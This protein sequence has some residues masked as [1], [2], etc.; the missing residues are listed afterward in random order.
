MT[1]AE[2]IVRILEAYGPP[3]IFG[4]PGAHTVKLHVA[5]CRSPRLRHILVRHEQGAAFA[6]DGYARVAGRPGVFVTTAGPGATNAVTPVAESFTNSVPTLHLCCL[7]D[8]PFVGKQLGAW[9]EADVESIFKPVTKWSVTARSA[10]ETPC[11]VLQALH[12]AA[13]GRPRPTQVC[14]PRDLLSETLTNELPSPLA[15]TSYVPDPT[16][17]DAAVEAIGE[18][19]R[20][21]IVAGGG[22]VRAAGQLRTL[23]TTL[24]AGVATTCMGKGVFPEDDPL[25]LGIMHSPAAMRALQEA[26]LCLA[27]GCRFTQIAT[28]NWSIRLPERL[29]HIDIDPYVIDMHYVADIPIVADAAVALEA[30]LATLPVCTISSRQAWVDRIRELRA[31]DRKVNRPEARL[32][33]LLRHQIPHE[34]LIVGDVAS[35]VYEMFRHFDA[36]RPASFLYPAG[37]IAMGYGLPA[38]VGAHFANPQAPLVC[39]TGDGSFQM[40]LAELATVVQNAVPVKIVLLNNDCLGSVAHFAAKDLNDMREVVELRNPNFVMLAQAFGIPGRQ[41][42]SQ[43]ENELTGGLRW[44]FQQEGSALLEVKWLALT[45][46]SQE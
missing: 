29:I 39:I 18:A 27:I 30:I 41:V 10:E 15:A 6:A 31:A 43:D 33:S 13:Q 9:H 26:D 8:R 14:I 21:I 23:A 36:Y 37:Y 2:A 35:L 34:A 40:T 22:C 7:V 38:A 42:R 46:V 17:I 5:I 32:S 19:K 20:P 24:Q 16:A 28:R 1:C 4:Y 11:L 12:E 3:V 25:S 45:D 44:L